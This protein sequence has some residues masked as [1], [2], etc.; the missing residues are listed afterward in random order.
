[1]VL[2]DDQNVWVS[3]Q[4]S[5]VQVTPELRRR[6]L[7]T[8]E[9]LSNTESSMISFLFKDSEGSIWIS[10][11]HNVV[12]F[13][14]A[15]DKTSKV[16]PQLS[17]AS[18]QIGDSLYPMESNLVLPYAKYD[19]TFNLA[20]ISLRDPNSIKYQYQLKG[21][22]DAWKIQ[23]GKDELNFT[24]LSQ[25]N[26]E[27]NVLA[28]KNGGEWT[29]EPVTYKFS[30][31]QPFWQSWWFW[32]LSSLIVVAG[33]L[34]FVRYR[35]YRLLRDKE[36]LEQIVQER[37]VEI[38][39]QKTEIEKSR[40]EIAKYAKDITDSIKYAKRIQNAI[41]PVQKEVQK[42]FPEC[43]VFFKSKDLVS[44]DFYFADKLGS[45]RIF[46][47][48]DCTGHGVPGGFMSIVANNL[49]QQAI[50][51][52]GLTKPSEI[53]NYASTGITNTLH[54]TYDESTVKDGMDVAL[55]TWNEETNLVEYAGAYNPLYLFRDG[56]LI[57]YK[58]D[59]F[60]AGTFIG[61]QVNRFTNHEIE[62][63]SGDMLYVFSDGFADQFGGPNGKKFMIRRF[64]KL[65]A[66]IHQKSLHEQ[67]DQLTLAY[68]NW[69]GNL[70]QVDDIVIMG[71]KIP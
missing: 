49:L 12:K 3:H 54:Q 37:T 61:E 57:E 20:G 65:L 27:L 32:M 64:K 33:V 45:K 41:F 23:D 48:V 52:N 58:G 1:M 30:I 21:A 14:P 13:N 4:K 71:V 16:R 24:G 55:C 18:M 46:A 47:A 9:E 35:T 17:I 50:R 44:G 28:S 66:E 40:D 67:H 29:T 62:V 26:Y 6:R 10:T 11:T 5:I 69:K 7:V 38:N 42:V 31:A 59:R 51:Q 34:L 68:K 2:D 63:K 60:P 70:E 8:R 36:A 56:K 39:E 15:I 25:G 19:I 53:L 22:S 43:M